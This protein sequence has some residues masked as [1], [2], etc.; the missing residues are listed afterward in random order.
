M[1]KKKTEVKEVTETAVDLDK[2]KGKAL[3]KYIKDNKLQKKIKG[4][5]DMKPKQ[6][7]AAIRKIES[8]ADPPTEKKEKAAPK[9]KKGEKK[10]LSQKA[11]KAKIKELLAN[12]AEAKENKDK[13]A[14]SKIRAQL[15]GLGYKLSQQ[16]K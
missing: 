4:F 14:A 8:P 12:L 10:P 9:S 13:S 3:K 5:E 11:Q 15:R 2:M 16:K 1:V 7:R 6:L